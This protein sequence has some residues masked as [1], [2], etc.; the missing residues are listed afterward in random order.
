[1][2]LLDA[3][4]F[5]TPTSIPNATVSVM[6]KRKSM[7]LSKNDP[8]ETK[9]T[10]RLLSPPRTKH[11]PTIRRP[12][13]KEIRKEKAE[14]KPIKDDSP[15][16]SEPPPSI[17]AYNLTQFFSDDVDDE[18]MNFS[19]GGSSTVSSFLQ[20]SQIFLEA[21][22]TAAIL[23]ETQ[24]TTNNED[25][26]YKTYKSA[27]TSAAYIEIQRDMYDA[28]TIREA[29]DAS[30]GLY[31]IVKEGPKPQPIIQPAQLVQQRRKGTPSA[32]QPSTFDNPEPG[33]FVP[34][35]PFF[36]LPAIVKTLIRDLRGKDNLYGR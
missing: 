17:Q 18:D 28:N 16:I 19:G 13:N 27:V 33:V 1:M 21:V 3:D 9:R 22:R 26:S 11:L 20:S 12:L 29:A 10:K 34:L 25:G 31:K 30:K 8:D 4:M 23:P 2:A 32:S 6:N 14:P 35:D 5:I 7:D 15:K 36:G 24:K